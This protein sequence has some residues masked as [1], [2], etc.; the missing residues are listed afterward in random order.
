[1][2]VKIKIVAINGAPGSGK[3]TFEEIIKKKLNHYCISRSSIDKVKEI[4][5]ICGW[6]GT[7]NLR[8]RKFLSDLK[9]LLTEYNDL[10]FNDI[11]NTKRLMEDEFN[12]YDL[13][14]KAL[15]LTDIREPKELARA[16]DEL[17]AITVVIRNNKAESEATSNHADSEVL[18]FDY[19]YCIYNNGTLE[20]LELRT[21][22][23]LNW[24]FE[25]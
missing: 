13:T 19:D 1:M 25:N 12:S 10:P 14:G 7:K 15:L 9:D 4:A 2:G 20:D 17:K 22:E 6:D 8:N 21:E 23:F 5:T 18:N 16:R 3:T 11:L 24:I